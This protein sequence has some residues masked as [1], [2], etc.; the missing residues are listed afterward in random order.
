MPAVG[1]LDPAVYDAVFLCGGHG[2]MWD[3]RESTTLARMVE[4]ID[5]RGGV[6][7]ALCHGPA[8]LLTA[9]RADGRPLV[10]GRRVTGF[11]NAEEDAVD[12][13]EAMPYLLE[14]EIRRLGGHY[15][16]APNFES[17]AV[18]DGRLVTGQNPASA[19][20]TAELTLAALE[21]LSAQVEGAL[22]R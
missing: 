19:R 15:V 11:S 2:T 16:S 1:S 5:R 4:N 6:V 20:L 13:T 9:N 14:D 22:V 7:S 18:R 3:F 12:L 8:G 21:D 17:H 10:L